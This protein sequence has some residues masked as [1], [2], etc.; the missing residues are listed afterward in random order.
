MAGV[1]GSGRQHVLVLA[2]GVPIALR[3]AF[4]VG[5]ARDDVVF[6]KVELVY[7]DWVPNS[8]FSRFLAFSRWRYASRSQ[9]LVPTLF[10]QG[11]R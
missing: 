6:V 4:C 7:V 10:C 11:G 3:L 8:S 9:V 5:L 2:A 1:C